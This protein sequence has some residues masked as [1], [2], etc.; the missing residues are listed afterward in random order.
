MRHPVVIA[1][2]ALGALVVTGFVAQLMLNPGESHPP[3]PAKYP[4]E[5]ATS[6]PVSYPATQSDRAANCANADVE[7]FL[8]RSAGTASGARSRV[9]RTRS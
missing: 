7:C 3:Q 6:Q 1:L 4:A 5:T 9:R 2:V 8:A